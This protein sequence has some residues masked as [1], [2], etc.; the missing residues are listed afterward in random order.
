MNTVFEVSQ[1]VLAGF[2]GHNLKRAETRAQAATRDALVPLELTHRTYSVLSLVGEGAD[3]NQGDMALTLGAERSGAVAI[4]DEL[5]GRGLVQQRAADGDRRA[6]AVPAT[7]QGR[8]LLD[9]ANSA[10]S[11]AEGDVHGQ[12]A[13]NVR[14]QMLRYLARTNQN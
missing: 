8:R 2:V 11:L 14:T 12:F 10:N 5:E 13:A 7:K 1:T 3:R 9:Y 6:H 4:V